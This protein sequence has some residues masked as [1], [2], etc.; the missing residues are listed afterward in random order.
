MSEPTNGQGE[1][2]LAD[3]GTPED[4]Q[5]KYPTEGQLKGDDKTPVPV[6]DPAERAEVDDEPV[7]T[8]KPDGDVIQRLGIGAGAHPP[9]DPDEYGPDGRP[10]EEPDTAKES[11]GSS[12]SSG[13]SSSSS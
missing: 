11:S 6:E 8:G 12:K 9:P 7:R 3:P 10:V 13:S 2:I 5:P 1:K 4:E